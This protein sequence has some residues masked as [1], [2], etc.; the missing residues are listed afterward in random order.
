[1]T[2]NDALEVTTVRGAIP[3][4]ELGITQT[5]EHIWL[6]AYEH[7]NSYQFVLEDV[8]TMVAELGEF[9]RRGG[10]SIVEVT[11]PEIGRDPLALKAISEKSGVHIIMGCGWYREFGYPP[12]VKEKTSREL[13]D[14]LIAE[15]E[16]GVRDTGVRPGII[17]EIGTGVRCILPAEERVFRAAALAQRKTGL[18]ITTHTTRWGELALEQIEMLDD[19]GADL[20]RVIIGHLGDRIGVRHLLPLAA[21]G[22]YLEIDNIGYIDYQPEWVRAD[23]VAALISE[24]FVKRILLSQDICLLSHLKYQNGN[25]YGYLLETFIPLLKERGVSDED[26]EMMLVK[27]PAR[28]LARRTT[29]SP[30]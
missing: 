8:D 26:I 2:S 25:G 16:C 21:R 17:G 1:M 14:D 24:G 4:E 10:K 6:N 3:A 7:Y 9:S 5:H 20:A 12:E 11:T 18:A 23:N 15:I 28:V 29:D 27:N 22:V 30:S 19:F 13:A